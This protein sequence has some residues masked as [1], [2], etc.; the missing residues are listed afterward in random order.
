MP[1]KDTYSVAAERNRQ[2]LVKLYHGTGEDEEEKR[3]GA[4]QGGRRD[5]LCQQLQLLL[6]KMCPLHIQ[7]RLTQPFCVFICTTAYSS[8]VLVAEA[9]QVL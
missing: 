4:G 1:E 9:L 7:K 8:K 3:G 5:G 2:R 6:R